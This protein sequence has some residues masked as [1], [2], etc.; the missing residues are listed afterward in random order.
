VRLEEKFRDDVE[1]ISNL[2]LASINGAWV[3]LADVADVSIEEG[4]I[5]IRR[6]N[7]QRRVVIQANVEGRDMGGLVAELSNRIENE[8][9][10]PSGYAVEFGGQYENQKR[11]QARLMIVVP[12][13]MA[14][15]FLLLYFAFG[16]MK[17]ASLI[18]LN[19]PMALVGGIVGLFISGQYLSVPG[20][21]GFITLFGIAILNGVVLVNSFNEGLEAGK[22]LADT[23]LE[24]T[25][26]RL[27]PVLMT[28]ITSMLGLIPLLLATG[29]GSEIQK[30]LAIVVV[31]GIITST[32]LTLVLLPAVY[33]KFMR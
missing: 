29:V 22:T 30:P 6:D 27:R 32:L 24:G 15:I 8:I 12:I 33:N 25:V 14:L 9:E 7:V 23:V 5:Q 11:A 1:S 26:S 13:S 20:S 10:L 17:Q 2:T 31:G 4:P 3:R 28:A 21:I 18:M 19:V 16:S